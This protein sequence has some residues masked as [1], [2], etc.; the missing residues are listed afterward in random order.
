MNNVLK[1]HNL[2]FV[3]EHRGIFKASNNYD[4]YDPNTQVIIMTCREEK[5]GVVTKIFRFTNYKTLTPFDIIVRDVNSKQV[6][7]VKRG[8]SMF[9]SKVQVFDENDINIGMFRQRLLNIG[10][11]FDVYDPNGTMLCTLKGKW[12][13]WDFKFGTKDVEY[14]SVTKKWAGLGR[15]LFTSAD[16]YMLSIE[17]TVAQNDTLREL[18]L[19]A[20]MCIDFVL[21]ERR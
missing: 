1:Q 18:I 5:L 9:R 16:N 2:F 11:K 20:V 14:A 8:F 12:H 17:P 4:I 10:G 15:E 6:I 21:K 13:S 19:A 7:R 3:K